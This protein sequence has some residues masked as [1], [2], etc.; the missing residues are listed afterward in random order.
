MLHFS[1]R[2]YNIRPSEWVLNKCLSIQ[3]V[4]HL[5]SFYHWAPFLISVNI[6]HQLC[7]SPE[8]RC[9]IQGSGDQ[10]DTIPQ[11]GTRWIQISTSPNLVLGRKYFCCSLLLLIFYRHYRLIWLL[12]LHKLRK[13]SKICNVSKI[14]PAMCSWNS[15]HF[16]HFSLSSK[17]ALVS[18]QVQAEQGA[19]CSW[20][21]RHW[22]KYLLYIVTSETMEKGIGGRENSEQEWAVSTPHPAAPTTIILRVVIWAGFEFHHGMVPQ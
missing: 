18:H 21:T 5:E 7:G 20:R 22:S 4:K 6:Q 8:T 19:H 10:G 17:L 15:L 14:R 13:N 2:I 12:L 3:Y 11:G 1:P 16:L 9:L